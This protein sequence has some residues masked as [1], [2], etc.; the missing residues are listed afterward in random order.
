MLTMAAV[1]SFRNRMSC[2]LVCGERVGQP[3]TCVRRQSCVARVLHG[4]MS[5]PCAPSL[6]VLVV[7]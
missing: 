7:S 4:E 3:Q 1:G 5:Q 2:R 6:A